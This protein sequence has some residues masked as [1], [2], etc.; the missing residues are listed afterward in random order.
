[1]K[2]QLNEFNENEKKQ[3]NLHKKDTNNHLNE[4]KK[5]RNKQLSEIR[6]TIQDMKG[7]FNKDI[8]SLKRSIK[9]LEIKSSLS[10][11]KNFSN[12]LSSRM[13]Q[14]E[15]RISDLETK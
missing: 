8:K 7:K 6:K 14:V 13:E 2:K 11:I 10:H 1:L 3:L 5:D 15:D 4:C 12:S 9:A